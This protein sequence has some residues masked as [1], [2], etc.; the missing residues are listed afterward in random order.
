MMNLYKLLAA[1]VACII[2]T[3]GAKAQNDYSV[4]MNT[5][6]APY[7]LSGHLKLGSNRAPD[8]RTLDANSLYFIKN[9]K[10]WFPVMGEIH[11]SRYPKQKWEESILKMKAAGIDV[12]ASYVLW[13]HH[14]EEKGDFEWKGNKD[15][16]LFAELCKKHGI[17]FF[18]RIGPWC[19][20]EVRNGGLPDWLIRL[21]KDKIRKNNREY[22]AEVQRFYQQIGEQLNG[23]YFKDGGSVIG[24]QIENE[25]R[26]NNPA[27]LEHMLTLK[28][29]A[30]DEGIDV[31]FYTATGWP[32]SDQKQD[33]L[34]PVW[35]GY[36]EAPW[37]SSVT[38]LAPSENYLFSNLRS[39][40]AIGSDLLGQHQTH[41][42]YTGYRYPYATA[43]MGA[44][45]Q[46]TYH[47]RPIIEPDDVTSL[48]YVKTGA[49]ANLMGYYMFHGG[50]NPIGKL[51]TMQESRATKYPND[52]PIIN[53]DFQS[54]L[55][56]WGQLRN[57]YKGFKTI[58]TFLNE[59][60]DRLVEYYPTFPEKMPSGA[61]D[62]SVLRFAVRS[63]DEEGF[64]FVSNFQRHIK[65]KDFDNVQFSLKSSGQTFSFPK[66][67]IRIKAGIQ[68][69]FPFN[70]RIESVNIKYATTQP[71][72]KIEGSI[73][74]YV[75]FAPEGLRPEYLLSNDGI[76][77]VNSK[78]G[79]VVKDG[80]GV[81]V[82]DMRPGA[83]EITEVLL[84]NGKKFRIL[85]LAADQ[86]QNAWKGTIGGV[87]HLFISEHELSFPGEELIIHS[88]GNTDIRFAVYPKLRKISA[89]NELVRSAD[90]VFETYAFKLSETSIK[91]PV[92]EITDILSYKTKSESD[93][94][95]D[96]RDSLVNNIGKPGPLYQTNLSPSPEARYY[97]FSL[98]P[99]RVD[100]NELFLKIYYTGDTGAAYLNGQLVADDFNSGLP[101]TIGL[102]RFL[103]D[104]PQKMVLQIMP[105]RIDNKIYLEDDVAQRLKRGVGAKIVSF[106]VVPKYEMT[107][108]VSP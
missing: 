93:L 89:P 108:T 49:G 13:I 51:S 7:L 71:F 23:L 67:P 35:G 78:T 5:A 101:M 100:L 4:D 50:S 63:K 36:P 12:I 56:E 64:V 34:I 70:M 16:R 107:L 42:E 14:E 47:R 10:P 15:L 24:V 28:R 45:N 86:I 77:E 88:E 84:R 98:P 54:P 6:H 87:Q 74:L 2:L 75:F 79:K 1:L 91:I 29:M 76:K 40:P 68:A 18:A 80:D 41:E 19:H 96:D 90:G 105:F 102:S 8:G 32:G 58:H 33:E 59:F 31:P 46:I 52:Y 25:Y 48:S 38:K 104:E 95:W 73:P 83:S 69:I 60:G 20:G 22:L 106:N 94:P 37:S 72:C 92:R 26:F 53:Y 65:M 81:F 27:G 44:G 99:G 85:T 61:S 97:E 17:F 30:R 82:A 43:E 55:G 66:K 3:G 9:G 21:G 62:N 103:T 11:Y 39:D 57:S